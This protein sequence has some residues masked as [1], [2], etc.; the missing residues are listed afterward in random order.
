MFHLLSTEIL[1]SVAWHASRISP[2]VLASFALTSKACARASD[3]LRLRVIHVT[4]PD[5]IVVACHALLAGWRDVGGCMEELS[6]GLEGP[7]GYNET[8]D[9]NIAALRASIGLLLGRAFGR[10]R[11]MSK[12]SVTV[13]GPEVRLSLDHA[14]PCIS[15]RRLEYVSLDLP[16][17]L[18]SS[19]LAAFL[20]SQP[21]LSHLNLPGQHQPY[22]MENVS[23]TLRTSPPLCYY[24]AQ[25]STRTKN[26]RLSPRGGSTGPAYHH[27]S[28]VPLSPAAAITIQ[29]KPQLPS[30]HY[31]ENLHTIRAPA[32]FILGL[33][34]V[35]PLSSVTVSDSDVPRCIHR[36]LFEKLARAQHQHEGSTSSNLDVRV[37]LSH[38]SFSL[39]GSNSSLGVFQE[40]TR[41]LRNLEVLEVRSIFRDA[42]YKHFLQDIAGC[43]SRCPN[44]RY[45]RF[46][47]P[48]G[49]SD[50]TSVQQLHYIR[51]PSCDPSDPLPPLFANS[52]H[53]YPPLGPDLFRREQY[54]VN[55]YGSTNPALRSV[56]MPSG[57]IWHW[58]L[59]QADED[60]YHHDFHP[61]SHPH[62]SQHASC[63][64]QTSPTIVPS[65]PTLR[66]VSPALS[67]A[68]GWEPDLSCLQAREW[69]EHWGLKPFHQNPSP[70]VSSTSTAVGEEEEED[71]EWT[72][73]D[74]IDCE[75]DNKEE[76]T[77]IT[78]RARKAL[79]ALLAVPPMVVPSSSPTVIPFAPMR[80]VVVPS[81]P[82]PARCLKRRSSAD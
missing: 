80:P 76:E 40:V 74:D 45:L 15:S 43:V 73:D 29:S 41:N 75:E 49:S 46:L 8:L 56:S 26:P 78:D 21:R 60:Q 53:A 72:G 12:L 20:S 42:Y 57:T 10:A 47:S 64:H 69:W 32:S 18:P 62:S 27:S 71:Y 1:L 14:L 2:H 67:T 16:A 22:P 13:V 28:A 6:I 24:G 81:Q 44:L 61:H 17:P 51:R 25:G 37:G 36:R 11:R 55:L 34:S 4:G 9:P 5:Q 35:C 66:Q 33:P 3:P 82:A 48:E 63:D 79:E 58:G 68:W 70:G 7:I 39:S 77:T 65:S 19:I 30:D 59:E 54:I 52:S 50:P 23:S 38:L 31:L